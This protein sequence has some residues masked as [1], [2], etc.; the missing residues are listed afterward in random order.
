MSDEAQDDC[1]YG[2]VWGYDPANYQD[3][4]A[5]IEAEVRNGTITLVGIIYDQPTPHCAQSDSAVDGDE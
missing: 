4:A 5:F 1:E 2:I 3:A